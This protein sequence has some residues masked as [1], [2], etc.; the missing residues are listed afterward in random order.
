MISTRSEPLTP[1]PAR[2][3]MLVGALAVAQVPGELLLPTRKMKSAAVMLGCEPE[4]STMT[5][6]IPLE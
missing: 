4:I 2:T 6:L 1:A 5:P 3:E